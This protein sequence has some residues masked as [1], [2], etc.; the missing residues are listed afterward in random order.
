MDPFS[1]AVMTVAQVGIS[2][3]FPSEGPRL[4]DLK[5]SAS[6]YGAVIPEAYGTVRVA[7]N[8]IWSDKIKEKKKKKRVGLKFVNTY[9]YS[10]TFAMACCKGPVNQIRKV[11]A[12]HKLVYD[13]TGTGELGVK[14][15]ITFK[16]FLGTED[17]LPA[18]AI[19]E[20]V[21]ED[22]TPGYRG[23]CYLLFENLPLEDFANQIPQISVEVFAAGEAQDAGVATSF[24]NLNPPLTGN[25]EFVVSSAW[26]L[27]VGRRDPV[28]RRYQADSAT[29]DF[30]QSI[31]AA[32][33]SYLFG[34]SPSSGNI[35]THGVFSNSSP[36]RMYDSFGFNLL[37]QIGEN[38]SSFDASPVG[39]RPGVFSTDREGNEYMGYV[40]VLQFWVAFKTF[41]VEDFAGQDIT[42]LDRSFA[43]VYDQAHIVGTVGLERPVF[44]VWSGGDSSG[45][46]VEQLTLNKHTILGPGVSTTELVFAYQNPEEGDNNTEPFVADGIHWDPSDGGCILVWREFQRQQIGKWSPFTGDFV[47]RREILGNFSIQA[48]HSAVLS[49][50]QLWWVHNSRLYMLDT[51]TGNWIAR[52]PDPYP[53]YEDLDDLPASL[54]TPPDAN[55]N[56]VEIFDTEGEVIFVGSFADQIYDPVYRRVFYG[57]GVYLIQAGAGP[58]EPV[59][60]AGLIERLLRRAGMSSGQFDVSG[61]RSQEIRGYG[62]ASQ[63]DLKSIIEQLRLLFLFDIVERDGK[64]VGVM[65]QT[66]SN[67]ER[68]GRPVR[69]LTQQ[70][71]G[72]TGDGMGM[73]YWAE[74][75]VQESDIPARVSLTYMNFDRDMETSTALSKRITEP[76]PTMFSRQQVALEMGVVLTATEAKNQVNKILWS[77]WAE[78]TRHATRLPWTYIELDPAD[79]IQVTMNDGRTYRERMHMMEIGAD[80]GVQIESFSQDSASYESNAIADGGAG[81]IPIPASPARQARPL[82][83]NTPLLRDQDDSGGGYS[84]YYSGIGHSA[85]EAFSGAGMWKG[86]TD[87]QY[88]LLYTTTQDVEW[89][90]VAGILAP[91]S[92][93][94]HGL[95][96]ESRLTI[97]PII[98]WFEIESITDDELWFGA[99]L[100]IVGD[101]VIQFRDCVQNTDGSWTIWNLLRGR[102][103][104]EYAAS[105]HKIG[106]TFTFLA[107][108]T[109]EADSETLDAN[110]KTLFFRAVGEGMALDTSAPLKITYAPRDL[111]PYAPKDIRRSL[112]GASITIDWKRR[113]RFGG[114]MQDGTEAVPLN[115]GNER[116]EFY[117][118][119]NAY[120][121][122]LSRGDEVPLDDI[123]FQAE[124]TASTITFDASQIEPAA[125]NAV[126]PVLTPF[127]VDVDTLHVLIYQLSSAVGRGFP[128]VRSIEPWQDF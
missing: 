51:T 20:V 90:Q 126:P 38:S 53:D 119:R 30:R 47:W 9:T 80:F 70:L 2:Y 91:P 59:T 55:Y 84:L 104:T 72:S 81:P 92:H 13:A 73:D 106:E 50:N 100:C 98:P 88:G 103:G 110:G 111:M 125:S 112:A 113:T 44:Y 15:P 21:G 12:N 64:L 34:I 24:V 33:D 101:E 114:N 120:D 65:R 75:R 128:G 22:N 61:L 27:G 29:E 105:N 68:V 108:T 95:D 48:V 54:I 63:S 14:K 10:C 79:V 99:N 94:A 62:W 82:V 4:K 86:Q 57:R 124:T 121:G 85:P 78:R 97:W 39:A 1:F 7:A 58:R 56:G 6:T 118:L 18:A 107:N 115:E 49:N 69:K 36:I 28:L 3:L 77:Q 83:F 25:S 40:S 35:L 43:G 102:R 122:D 109:I 127:D 17:Q 19:A 31:T 93:G 66:G 23:L 42:L 46:Y 8:M 32:N 52:I 76:V 123:I 67:E 5:I 89:G 71:L 116:Y 45:G 74:S 16:T 11:W 37:G 41:P 117:I 60:L 96:W 26:G 87:L